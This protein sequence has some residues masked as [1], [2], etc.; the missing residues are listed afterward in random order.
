MILERLRNDGS[1]TITLNDIQI[2]YKK[3]VEEK[4]KNKHY[5]FETLIVVEGRELSQIKVKGYSR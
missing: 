1:P 5:Q 2:K 3:Q 4:I